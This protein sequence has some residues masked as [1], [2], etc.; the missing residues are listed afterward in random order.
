MQLCQLFEV[1]ITVNA[2]VARL[3]LQDADVNHLAVNSDKF[4][5]GYC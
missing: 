1:K 3:G 5:L 2:T 4:L